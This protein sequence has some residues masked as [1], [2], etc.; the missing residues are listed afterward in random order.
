M[1]FKN[2]R[3]F[4]QGGGGGGKEVTIDV[5]YFKCKPKPLFS[6]LTSIKSL[7]KNLYE[8]E[9]ALRHFH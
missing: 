9:P 2:N 8:V 6:L 3:D 4:I 1:T 5:F 7:K